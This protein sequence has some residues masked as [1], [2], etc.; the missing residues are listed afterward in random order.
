MVET[1]DLSELKELSQDYEVLDFDS[2]EAAF[3]EAENKA[4]EKPLM[5]VEINIKKDESGVKAIFWY[6]PQESE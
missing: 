1:M 4:K 2:F 5:R 3:A 6:L